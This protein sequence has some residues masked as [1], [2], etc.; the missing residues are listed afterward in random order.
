MGTNG[1]LKNLKIHVTSRYRNINL[2]FP[3]NQKE[4]VAFILEVKRET[5]SYNQN[6]IK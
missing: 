5:A 1:N 2:E 6:K 3:E 4:K